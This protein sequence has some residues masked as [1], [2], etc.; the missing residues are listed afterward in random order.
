LLLHESVQKVVVVMVVV[1]RAAIVQLV[2][3]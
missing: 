2:S 3:K 1:E